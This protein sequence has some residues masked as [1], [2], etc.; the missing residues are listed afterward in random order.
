VGSS[1]RPDHF[2]GVAAGYARFRPRYPDA[3]HD[4]LMRQVP[5]GARAWDCAT[6]SGQVALALAE[7]L[8]FV[9]ASDASVAQ[10][11]AADRHPRVRYV[12]AAAEQVPLRDASIDLVTVAQALHWF[13][14]AAFWRELRRV[15]AP[16]GVVAAWA[17]GD[18]VLGEPLDDAAAPVL[19]RLRPYWPPER[20]HILAGY[21][22]IPFPFRELEPPALS[23]EQAW[24]REQFLGYVGTWSACAPYHEATGGDVVAELR[25]ALAPA[26]PATEVRR[27]RWP[28]VIRAGRVEGSI[29]G[30]A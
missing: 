26:W 8:P 4:W 15:L 9:L 19:A 1:V 7:R 21:R 24:D 14:A 23:L 5:H 17:Y 28:M 3:L 12:A 10:L 25:D 20:D 27:V 29:A 6:G 11:R 22:T 30:T 16:G 13:D 18:V 2:S